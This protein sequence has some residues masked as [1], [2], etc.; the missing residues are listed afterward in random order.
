LPLGCG[1]GKSVSGT[2]TFAG[3]EVEAGF[4][5]FFPADGKGNTKGAKIVG[6]QYTIT[7]LAPG[8]KRVLVAAEPEAQ[9]VP[10]PKNEA[11]QVV[12]KFP[13][14]PIPPN[15]VG[16]NQVVDITG[17]SQTLDFALGKP[18]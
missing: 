15:A 18:R 17:G 16:N 5:T 13:T 10:T 7:G 1:G 2:V 4:I 8:Q 11:P 14:G 9:V 12:A 3:K 6:G